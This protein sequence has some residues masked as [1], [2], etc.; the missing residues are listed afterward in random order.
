MTVGTTLPV[1]YDPV[2]ESGGHQSATDT[3]VTGA[4][5]RKVFDGPDGIVGAA[6]LSS[7]GGVLSCSGDV[8]TLAPCMVKV[9]G[10]VLPVTAA[11]AITLPSVATTTVYGIGVLADPSKDTLA[12]QGG[13][14]TLWHGVLS[15]LSVP[16]GGYYYPLYEVTRQS[17]TPMSSSTSVVGKVGFAGYTS[18]YQHTNP[19]LLPADSLGS[20]AILGDGRR[21]VRVPDGTSSAKWATG[22]STSWTSTN[23]AVVSGKT[24]T[25]GGYASWM[26]T[27]GKTAWKL[28]LKWSGGT[29]TANSSNGN[30]DDQAV[31]TVSPAPG[32]VLSGAAT[33]AIGGASGAKIGASYMVT[34]TGV[35]YLTSTGP[36]LQITNNSMIYTDFDYPTPV[37]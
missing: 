24:S 3:N 2:Q 35:V 13:Y 11:E 26:Q 28:A 8:A 14:L 6:S 33:L 23:F 34:E 19:A 21:Y 16:A 32:Y 5:W 12:D 25:S 22:T 20:A 1:M 7:G 18:Y 37:S 10:F 36:S 31:G 9:N 29:V 27:G 17:S 4:T 15:A 30:L